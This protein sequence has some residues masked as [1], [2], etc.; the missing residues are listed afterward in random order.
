MVI[1]ENRKGARMKTSVASLLVGSA[2]VLLLLGVAAGP[3]SAQT[4]VTA[5]GE[6]LGQT[7][8]RLE[9]DLFAAAG[10]CLTINGNGTTLFLNGH[11]I[12]G[13]TGAAAGIVSTGN[14]HS[15]VGPGV[16]HDFGVCIDL[17]GRHNFVE[18]VL[19]Y[20]CQGFGINLGDFAKC[21]Q[22]R[23]HDVRQSEPPNGIGIALGDGCI[24]ESSISATSDEGAQVGEDCKVWDLV[25]DTVGGTG[26]RVGVG[27]TVARTVISHYHN[28]PGLDYSACTDGGALTGRGCQDSSNSVTLSTADGISIATPPPGVPGVTTD[29]ATNG[30]NG[31]PNS[32]GG[33][34][35][36]LGSVGGCAVATPAI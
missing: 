21:V 7:S 6:L 24:L 5:C 25:V 28:G 11:S 35:K 27:T 19:A 20:N 31:T 3:V 30:G 2:V 10:T 15:I 36:F 17:P 34:H 12:G 29:C 22:C 4:P 13:F 32:V 23:V 1:S 8:Y 26:L 16:V 14:N 9:A 33:G 18:S